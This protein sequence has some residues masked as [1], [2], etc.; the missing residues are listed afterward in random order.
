MARGLAA[1]ACGD[2][3]TSCSITKHNWTRSWEPPTTHFFR[4]GPTIGHITSQSGATTWGPR[5]QMQEPLGILHISSKAGIISL[6]LHTRQASRE[7][8]G[9]AVPCG[10]PQLPIPACSPSLL[11]TCGPFGPEHKTR[12]ENE[13]GG[14]QPAAVSTN[15]WLRAKSSA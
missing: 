13:P 12:T 11:P 2:V 10:R 7:V 15:I 4:L 3:L 1:R 6:I 5:F 14:T 8:T 9:H